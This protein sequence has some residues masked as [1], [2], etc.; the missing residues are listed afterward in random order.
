MRWFGSLFKQQD[1][2]Y[3]HVEI[4]NLSIG[5]AGNVAGCIGEGLHEFLGI[6]LGY[7]PGEP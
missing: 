7:K 3:S 1:D 4:D 6:A 2:L 5:V